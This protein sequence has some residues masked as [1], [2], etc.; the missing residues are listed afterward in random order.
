MI[1]LAKLVPEEKQI[2]DVQKAIQAYKAEPSKDNKDKLQLA[3][4]LL[5]TKFMTEGRELNDVMNDVSDLRK[6][7]EAKEVPATE[8]E[9]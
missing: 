8:K 1:I 9:S 5:S 4:V 7:V 2:D 3:T 6:V